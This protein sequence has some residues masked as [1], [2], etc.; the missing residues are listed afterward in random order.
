MD[1]GVLER[2]LHPGG[3]LVVRVGR[4]DLL[5]DLNR[6]LVA[7]FLAKLPG[8]IHQLSDQT[9]LGF[10]G[11]ANASVFAVVYLELLTANFIFVIDTPLFFDETLEV[12]GLGPLVVK[13]CRGGC[14]AP[15][16]ANGVL[17]PIHQSG[18]FGKVVAKD[19]IANLGLDVTIGRHGLLPE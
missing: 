5:E 13:A 2:F 6:V 11:S 8:L 17:G 1:R 16:R 15:V 9:V 3:P 4:Q 19:G 7:S 14:I 10:I 12:D 18:G